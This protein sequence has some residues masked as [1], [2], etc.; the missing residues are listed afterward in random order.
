MTAQNPGIL[1]TISAI[2][3]PEVLINAAFASL[4]SIIIVVGIIVM[5]LYVKKLIIP[6]QKNLRFSEY[7]KGLELLASGLCLVFV[8]S[9]DSIMGLKQSTKPELISFYLAISLIYVLVTLCVFLNL[10]FMHR[11]VAQNEE[12]FEK[13]NETIK[14][15]YTRDKIGFESKEVL[16]KRCNLISLISNSL[17]AL[18]L[19]FAIF[20]DKIC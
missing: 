4:W 12:Y 9:T 20:I 19:Y 2:I 8:I 1:Q 16:K 6:Y 17:G 18:M 14:R 11:F 13:K 10:M 15:Q 5:L 3:T 7:C